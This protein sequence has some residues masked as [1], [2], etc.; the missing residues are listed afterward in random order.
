MSADD[1]VCDLTP[2]DSMT[3]RFDRVNRFGSGDAAIDVVR[4]PGRA[5]DEYGRRCERTATLLKKLPMRDDGRYD[6]SPEA[7]AAL[8][9][10][11]TDVLFDAWSLTTVRDWMPGRPPV[12]RLAPRSPDGLAAGPLLR[13]LARRSARDHRHLLDAYPPDDVLDDFPLSADGRACHPAASCCRQ[14]PCGPDR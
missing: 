5:E 7:L 9:L 6:S 11:S 10:A 4:V 12:R 1:L 14:T 8:L 3:Q 13:R 2:F